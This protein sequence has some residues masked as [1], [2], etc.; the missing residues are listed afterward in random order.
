MLYDVVIF[1]GETNYCNVTT[2]CHDNKVMAVVLCVCVCVC[3]CLHINTRT[4][5][6]D[7]TQL[8]YFIL[9]NS[10]S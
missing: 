8:G 4:L 1:S 9:Y 7:K 3:V 10:V 2:A 6:V 5:Y